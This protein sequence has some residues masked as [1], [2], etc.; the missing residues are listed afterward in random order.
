[1]GRPA[2]RQLNSLLLRHSTV[3]YTLQVAGTFFFHPA[4]S[5]LQSTMLNFLIALLAA[6]ATLASAKTVTYDF[7]IGWVTAAP[8]GYSRQVIGINGQWP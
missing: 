3:Y 7:D 8:D 6:H 2:R 5:S 1:M 4:H